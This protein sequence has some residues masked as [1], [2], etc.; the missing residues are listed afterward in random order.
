MLKALDELNAFMA[1]RPWELESRHFKKLADEGWNVGQMVHAVVILATFHGLS[2]I[3]FSLGLKL[4]QDLT[5]DGSDYIV[6]EPEIET[7]IPLIFKSGQANWQEHL[8]CSTKPGAHSSGTS[9]SSTEP[10]DG[11]DVP[12][13]KNGSSVL[14]YPK[15]RAAQRGTSN[16]TSNGRN[17]SDTPA[18]T[19]KTTPREIGEHNM[20]NFETKTCGMFSPKRKVDNLDE[21]EKKDQLSSAM[22]S[23]PTMKTPAA[24]R[25][26]S[27][28]FND[29]SY[30]D[31]D[32]TGS[33][34]LISKHLVEWEDAR[35]TLN[36]LMHEGQIGEK[37]DIEWIEAREYTNNQVGN[38][39]YEDH[40]TDNIRR[41]LEFCFLF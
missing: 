40:A 8:K 11:G 37:V 21:G 12:H 22:T 25:F 19:S 29:M 36:S 7:E 38:V 6:G 2:S 13:P 18:E 15:M 26:R 1:H 41:V 39:V 17:G 32:K 16:G 5:F 23:A 20:P 28:E 3:V 27:A 14:G 24:A 30:Q 31:F 34:K 35:D 33:S 4:E 9:L 10:I